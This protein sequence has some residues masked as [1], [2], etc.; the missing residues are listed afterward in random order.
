MRGAGV[1]CAVG[2]NVKN[3]QAGDAVSVISSFSLTQYGTYTKAANLPA[4]SAVKH[5]QNL[6]FKEM[7]ASWMT[8]ISTYGGLVKFTK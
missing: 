1:V 8:F 6:S 5:P 3:I 4:H 2:T 7:V